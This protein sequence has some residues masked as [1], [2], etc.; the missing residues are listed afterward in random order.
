[1]K[2]KIAAYANYSAAV[3]LL[4]MGILYLTKS[5]FMS[6]HGIALSRS[7]DEI[8]PKVRILI[9]ALMRGIGGGLIAASVAIIF[10]QY[11]FTTSKLRWIPVLIMLIGLI[12]FCTILYAMLIV[13]FNTPG[14]PPL[15]LTGA[16][17]ALMVTAFLL[18]M[19]DIHK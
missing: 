11:K 9:L 12:L 8:D 17:M 18:N 7:W 13:K 3:I 14:N 16:G 15:A 6:Y 5:S 1:M 2:A 10:L 19:N 4:F